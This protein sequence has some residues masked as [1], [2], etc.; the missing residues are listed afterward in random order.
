MI[1]R[2]LRSFLLL[3]IFPAIAGAQANSY[4]FSSTTGNTLES[5]GFT[6]LLGTM[7]DDNVSPVTGIGFT[8]RFA[9]TNYTNFSATSNGL[10][11]LGSA[12]TSSYTNSTSNLNG[13]YLIPYWDDNYTDADGNVQYKIMGAAG[14]RKL[15]VDY[16]LSFLGNTG[17]A[18][19]HFQVWLFETSNT[20]QFVYGDGND[21]NGEFTVGILTNGVNDFIAVN[22]ATQTADI[23]TAVDDNTTWPGTGMSYSFTA[24]GTLPVSLLNFSGY[25]DGGHIQLQWTTVTE[26]NNR[27]FEVQRS[28]D[29]NDFTTIGFVNSLA[30]GGN[31]SAV[32]NYQFTDNIT[33]INKYFYRLRQVDIDNR[34]KISPVIVIDGHKITGVQVEGVFPNPASTTLNLRVAASERQ[35]LTITLHDMTGKIILQKIIPVTAGSNAIPIDIGGLAGSFYLLKIAD[36]YGNSFKV[37]KVTVVK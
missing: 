6:N 20:I 10:L 8:F 30:V 18:D 15:V 24:G 9:G 35:S 31:S 37:L 36:P 29:G 34:S 2:L 27:G 21:F 11:E 5:G 4:S 33:S 13:P 17:F 16:N 25:K 26:I 1:V 3:F 7:L 19:K 12:A 22:T 23:G 32:L 14:S 28:S